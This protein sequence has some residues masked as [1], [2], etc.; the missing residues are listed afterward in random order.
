MGR[1]QPGIRGGRDG[2][3]TAR[4]RRRERWAD[5]SQGLGEGEMGRQQPGIGGGRDGQ[6]TARDRRRERWADNS[7]G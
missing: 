3:T 7:Q 4:D 5:N 1:Q 6:T 2:Q